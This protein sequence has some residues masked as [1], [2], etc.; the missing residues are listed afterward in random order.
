MST[1]SRNFTAESTSTKRRRVFALDVLP[2][3]TARTRVLPALRAAQP[4]GSER[5]EM[6]EGGRR[7]A[8]RRLEEVG[9][10]KANARLKLSADGEPM[11]A[12]RAGGVVKRFD[13]HSDYK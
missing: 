7:F 10:V 11:R 4:R 6:F 8:V 9:Q 3:A 5:R 2:A 12:D 1:G 13:D